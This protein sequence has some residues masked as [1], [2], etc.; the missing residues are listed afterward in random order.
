MEIMKNIPYFNNFQELKP[1]DKITKVYNQPLS[2]LIQKL[3]DNPSEVL[4]KNYDMLISK[5]YSYLG[6]IQLLEQVRAIFQIIR[7]LSF[8]KANE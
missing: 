7:N 3:K 1:Q 5:Q 4:K 6:E 2:I 8:T